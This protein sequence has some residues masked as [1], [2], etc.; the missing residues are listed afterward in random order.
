MY[1]VRLCSVVV[2]RVLKQN[3]FRTLLYTLYTLTIHSRYT[4]SAWLVGVLQSWCWALFVDS[5]PL[6]ASLSTLRFHV[7]H[8]HMHTHAYDL[9]F[10]TTHTH[11]HSYTLDTRT[12][13]V[14]HRTRT[15]HTQDASTHTQP[16][17]PSF[18]TFFIHFSPFTRFTWQYSIQLLY[19]LDCY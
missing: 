1:L 19:S 6:L 14:I 2:H 8:T 10:H 11:T 5:L 18:Y 9:N 12:R 3:F 4:H 7:Q 15:Q 16:H 13:T 17:T